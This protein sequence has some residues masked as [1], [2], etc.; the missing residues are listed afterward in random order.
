MTT[1]SYIKSRLALAPEFAVSGSGLVWINGKSAGQMAG[2]I[3][4][5]G[6]YQVCLQ[7]KFFRA[8]QLVAMLADIKDWRLPRQ[9]K[10][11]FVIDHINGR[12]YDNRPENLR[13][14]T[15]RQNQQNHAS[16]RSGRLVG[17]T[18]YK[19]AG[20]WRSQIKVDGKIVHLGL[21]DTEQ[22]AHEAYLAA[23]A[24]QGHSLI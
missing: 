16:H 21:F 22:I 11:K 9:E 15:A 1:I 23:L 3:T 17:T 19:A 13:V 7:G 20:K 14:V 18:F 10:M 5:K 2:T 12:R 8:H 6:Y 4:G 24:E